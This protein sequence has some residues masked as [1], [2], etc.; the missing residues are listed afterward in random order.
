MR[1]LLLLGVGLVVVAAL[2]LIGWRSDALGIRTASP[3]ASVALAFD[4]PPAYPGYEWTRDGKTVPRE[5]IAAIAGPEHCGWQSATL[6]S[7]GWPPG[8]FAST[9]ALARRYVRDPQG[10]INSSLRQRLAVNIDLPR[11]ARPTGYRLGSIEIYLS[12][13][14]Q[15]EAIY[16]VGPGGSERWPRSDPMTLCA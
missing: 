4:S 15:D 9:A 12:P 10:A 6:L 5:E 14:D 1:R 13:S 16:V 2:I 7:I 11:D 8:T 3:W